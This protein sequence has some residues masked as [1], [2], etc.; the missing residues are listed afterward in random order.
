MHPVIYSSSSSLS[1]SSSGERIGASLVGTAVSNVCFLL[2]SSVDCAWF[3][4]LDGKGL[5]PTVRVA[6][7]MSDCDFSTIDN[8]SI[9][10]LGLGTPFFRK[11]KSRM[12]TVLSYL[13]GTAKTIRRQSSKIAP[14]KIPPAKMTHWTSS[15]SCSRIC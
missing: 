12:S 5:D 4:V 9:R 10:K 11:L 13:S 15:D 3:T 14:P 7:T 8:R 6:T 2:Q 1:S